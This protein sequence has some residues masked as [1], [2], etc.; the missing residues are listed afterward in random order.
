MFAKW[1]KEVHKSTLHSAFLRLLLL[2]AQALPERWHHIVTGKYKY[3]VIELF[4]FSSSPISSKLCNFED[5][6]FL[7]P[8][9]SYVWK[10]IQFENSICFH[11][12]STVWEGVALHNQ[13]LCQQ[14]CPS[15][16]SF[17]LKTE[18]ML[19][20][21]WLP[22]LQNRLSITLPGPWLHTYQKMFAS[23]QGLFCWFIWQWFPRTSVKCWCTL[24]QIPVNCQQSGF[25]CVHTPLF[26][27]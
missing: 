24:S 17:S 27:G 9:W 5:C 14:S 2:W 13:I 26:L 25:K 16:N 10:Q 7:F 6:D 19:G 3:I 21:L 15:A 22:S 8:L 20:F 11:S 23:T 12:I 1:G 4:F 18:Q